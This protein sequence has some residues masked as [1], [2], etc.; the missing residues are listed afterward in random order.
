MTADTS[1]RIARALISDVGCN[2]TAVDTDAPS[3]MQCM[4]S[5]NA[6]NI[7]M[8]QWNSYWGILGFPS[9]PTVD[10][11]FLPKH[12]LQMLKEG[13]FKNTE[14]LVGTNQDEGTL[15]NRLRIVILGLELRLVTLCYVK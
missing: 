1:K 2:A 12:P 11:V 6:R 14:I 13:D 7:S 9:A 8:A 3:V 5:V 10:G 4:R 15:R